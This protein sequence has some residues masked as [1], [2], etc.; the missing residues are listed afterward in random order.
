MLQSLNANFS[1][2]NVCENYVHALRVEYESWNDS[3]ATNSELWS[4]LNMASFD[5]RLQ[6][7]GLLSQVY[8]RTG[9]S[10]LN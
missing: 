10:W 2:L 9:W 1:S 7:R 3:M 8:D 4:L 5:N 6:F